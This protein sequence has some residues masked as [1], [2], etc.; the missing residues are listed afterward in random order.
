MTAMRPSVGPR[1]SVWPPLAPTVHLRRPRALPFPLDQPSCVLFSKARHGLWHGFKALGMGDGD[2]ILV[3]AYHHG[4][5]IQAAMA[6]GLRCIFYDVTDQLAPDPRRLD[7]LLEP[8]VRALHITHYFGFPQNSKLWRRWC[9]ERGLLLV[10]DAAQAWLAQRDGQN[11]GTYG[12]LSI[13]CL[14]KMFGLPDGGAVL[15]KA[16]IR[17]TAA[18]RPRGGWMLIRR[19][20]AWLAQL[21]GWAMHRDGRSDYDAAADFDLGD[22]RTPA[23]SATVMVLPRLDWPAVAAARRARY[24][25]LVDALRPLVP[26]AFHSV[27][28]G[29]A[30]FLLPLSVPDKAQLL[31]KL[32]AKRLHALDIWAVPHPSMD[33]TAFPVAQRLRRHLI[34]LPVHQELRPAHLRRIVDVVHSATR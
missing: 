14:D 2:A 29:A 12:D 27:P 10:E 19:H 25:D 1:L 18:S 23:S 31:T 5:E 8:A 32:A 21:G 30:P 16:P 34:G 9:D 24:E 11:V 3:P 26:P 33:G 15:C 6:A 4:S 13:F 7:D 28:S 22:P 20:L 17:A